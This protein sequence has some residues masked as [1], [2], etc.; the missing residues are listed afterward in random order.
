MVFGERPKVNILGVG[1]GVG[2]SALSMQ[3]AIKQGEALPGSQ[4]QGIRLRDR[5]ARHHRDADGAGISRDS[6][7]IV[8][9][10][11]R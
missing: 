9:G 11:A 4:W 7:S 10:N 3:S 8:P 2:V 5:G 1:V 6:Q